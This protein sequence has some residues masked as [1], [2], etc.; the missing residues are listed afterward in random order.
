[1]ENSVKSVIKRA[2]AAGGLELKRLNSS[3]SEEACVARLLKKASCNLLVDIGANEGQYGEKVMQTLPNI[4]MLSFEPLS[5]PYSRLNMAAKR[6]ARWAVA[7]R[8]A[9]GD[10]D[11]TIEINISNNSVSSSI[12]SMESAHS[13]AEPNSR[14]IGREQV[15]IKRLDTILPKYIKGDERIYLKIDTQGYEKNVVTGAKGILSFITAIQLELSL[16]ELYSGQPLA[17][18][19][20]EYMRSLGF[21]PFAFSNVFSNQTTGELL[22]ID[23]FFVAGK[24][25]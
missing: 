15:V 14:Y 1:M 17:F 7:E 11:G 16:V 6:Y 20:I 2:L 25:A 22:Q 3:N 21:V 18:E 24:V 5:A 19:M 4:R 9:I 23:A 13:N 10:Q 12:L 8:C